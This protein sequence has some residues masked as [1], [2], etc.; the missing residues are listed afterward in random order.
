MTGNRPQTDREDRLIIGV[1]V[2]F[3]AINAL[4]AGWDGQG[5]SGLDLPIRFVLAIPALMFLM[6]YPPRHG[7]LWSGLALG[8]MASGSWA[9]WQKLVEENERARG[10]THVI[11]YGDLN[12]LMGVMCLAGLGWACTRTRARCWMAFLAVGACMGIFGSLM[13]GSR[14]GWIG[15]PIILWVIY[16]TYR[17]HIPRRWALTMGVTLLTAMITA[18]AVPSLGIQ[19][20]V[21]AAFSN[22]TAFHEQGD[23]HTSLGARFAMWETAIR[24]IPQKPLAG[25]GLH[26]YEQARDR[27]IDEGV[28]SPVIGNYSHVHNEY[29]DAWLKRGIPGLV[30]LLALYLVPL[31]LFT[32]RLAREDLKL[33]ALALA[34]VLL[35]INYMDFGLS[36]V[37]MAHNSGV[38]MYSFWLVV[39]WASVRSRERHLD[40]AP[41]A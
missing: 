8:A 33:R 30:L 26:G 36:Q 12:M 38:M 29:L 19:H 16:R 3:F 35:P 27:L 13:S 20:R 41:T 9:G 1:L 37:F 23:T 24:L 10:F 2:A 5:V 32:K 28:A 22:V 7:W 34:G 6:K 40:A 14:G 15:F 39:L 21:N 25:Y 17:Q 11:Q 18:Y 31:K 4:E